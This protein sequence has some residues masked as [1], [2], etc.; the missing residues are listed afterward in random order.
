MTPT[1]HHASQL[2]EE[3]HSMDNGGPIGG[4]LIQND[5]I[6]YLNNTHPPAIIL[7]DNNSKDGPIDGIPGRRLEQNPKKTAAFIVAMQS[8]D[9]TLRPLD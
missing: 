1:L 7:R 4:T 5:M 9:R 8:G 6:R 2:H 3:I